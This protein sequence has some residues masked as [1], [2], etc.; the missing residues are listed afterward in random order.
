MAGKN[1]NGKKSLPNEQLEAYKKEIGRKYMDGLISD[2]EYEKLL[3][4]REAELGKNSSAADTGQELECPSCGALVDGADTECAICGTPLTPVL[5]SSGTGSHALQPEEMPSEETAKSNAPDNWR[6]EWLDKP[7]RQM[8][9]EELLRQPPDVLKGVSKDDSTR[10]REAFN[11]RTLEDFATAKYLI[12]AQELAA[13]KNSASFKKEDFKHKLDKKYEK[14]ELNEI[15]KAPTS[16]LQGISESDSKKLAKAFNTR[17]IEELG[18]LKYV[19]WANMIHDM[20]PPKVFK[21]G[22]KVLLP[23]GQMGKVTYVTEPDFK[24]IQKVEVAVSQ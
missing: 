10:M 9:A 7:Y 13:L 19:A 12:W 1:G 23:S 24:G 22:D 16:A 2:K 5:V 17:T 8:P 18:S 6:E 3:R 4:D 14:K 11:I 21:V 20:A 15:L